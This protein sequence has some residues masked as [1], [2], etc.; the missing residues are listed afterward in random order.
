VVTGEEVKCFFF[1]PVEE[2]ESGRL[3]DEP[4]G[5]DDNPARERLQDQRQAPREV[6]VHVIGAERHERGGCDVSIAHQ[7]CQETTH[8]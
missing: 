5:E 3:G 1:A 4:N 2:Q 6:V 7:S 8:G